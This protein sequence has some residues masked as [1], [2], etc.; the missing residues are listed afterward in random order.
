MKSL[1]NRHTKG[2]KMIKV[3]IIKGN[4]KIQTI[5]YMEYKVSNIWAKL[6]KGFNLVELDQV[7]LFE[8]NAIVK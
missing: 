6:R 3:N 2:D 4:K 5:N 7:N 8:Y 1:I